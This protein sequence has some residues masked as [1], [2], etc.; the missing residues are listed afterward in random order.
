MEWVETILK[1]VFA[2]FVIVPLAYFTARF[3]GRRSG[4]GAARRIVRLLEVTSLGT[5]RSLCVVELPGKRLLV[6]GVTAQ[7][8]RVLAEL[9][10]PD[11]ID[12][13]LRTRSAGESAGFA[14]L[15]R[16]IEGSSE[17]VDERQRRREGDGKS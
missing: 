8:I 14:G 6:L 1:V 5:G 11:L 12:E 15:L 17:V 13:A 9:T 7:Q 2:L 4:Y 10:D 3:Y 16:R